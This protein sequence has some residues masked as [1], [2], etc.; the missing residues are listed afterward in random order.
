[1]QPLKRPE[2]LNHDTFRIDNILFEVLVGGDLSRSAT[3]A[4]KVVLLKGW[5][6]V[7]KELAELEDLKISRMMEIGIWQGGSAVLWP[8]VTGLTTY[9]GLDIQ[10]ADFE[11]PQA[12]R[13]HPRFRTVSLHGHISQDDR[14]K[15]SAVIECQLDGP[16]DLIIDDASHQY[17]FSK[18]TFDILF[19]KLRAGGVY[20]IE[21]WAWAHWVGFQGP[22]DQW[23]ENPALTNLVFELIM[24]AGSHAS[25]IPRIKV[26][27]GFVMVWRGDAA[28]DAASFTLDKLILKRGR[29]L[30]GI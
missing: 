19:P 15:V 11:F 28:L 18:R 13:N 25:V 26:L 21:D 20:I 6:F 16:L 7:E 30:S 5:D 24:A 2:F 9:V 14:A 17:F 10:G 12:V 22:E 23:V 8:L 27:P 3:D 1:M 29:T 4:N